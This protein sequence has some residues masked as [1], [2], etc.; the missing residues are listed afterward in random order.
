VAASLPF[1]GLDPWL[2]YATVLRHVSNV[3]GVPR[4]LDLGSTALALGVIPEV[5]NVFLIGGYALAIVAILLGL[6]RDREIGYVV[7]LMATLLLSPLLWDHYLTNLIVPAALLASRGRRFAVLLPLLG[8]LP[9][10]FLPLVTI[11]GMLLPFLA[12]DRGAKALDV[13]RDEPE[14]IADAD[15]SL[16]GAAGG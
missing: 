1:V 4:N 10:A 15:P 16:S 11:L 5:S 14:P 8:W 13:S 2:Q 3:M 9:L 7:T 6:R 12:P